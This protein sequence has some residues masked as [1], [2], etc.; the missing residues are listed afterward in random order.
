LDRSAGLVVKQLA[1]TQYTK[2]M[3]ECLRDLDEA[4]EYKTDQLAIQL[5]LIQRLTEKI[6]HFHSSDTTVD[7][8]LGSHEPSKM[9]R[10]EALR[11]ELDSLRNALPPHLKSDCMIPHID[12]NPAVGASLTLS[13]LSIVLPQ[14]C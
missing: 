6:F 14:Q 2:Y 10:L 9:A 13:R 1:F 8:Q 11:V 3:D 5:V 4:R 12:E 7:E